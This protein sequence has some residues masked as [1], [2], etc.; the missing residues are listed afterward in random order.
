LSSD[1][2]RGDEQLGVRE[3]DDDRLPFS[4]RNAHTLPLP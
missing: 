2:E 1:A 4:I 3:A